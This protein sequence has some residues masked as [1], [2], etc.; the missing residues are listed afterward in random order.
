M[1]NWCDN[2][3]F[4]LQEATDLRYIKTF[5]YTSYNGVMHVYNT[6]IIQIGKKL[7][8]SILFKH[9]NYNNCIN[10]KFIMLLK[11]F[12][13]M[14]TIKIYQCILAALILLRRDNEFP[15]VILKNNTSARDF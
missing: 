8:K 14:F 7:S 15:N 2:T 4:M 12:V 11:Y 6:V 10:R 3:I 9:I 1:L 13:K 5:V